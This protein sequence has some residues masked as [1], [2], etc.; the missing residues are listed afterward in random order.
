MA[1][2]TLDHTVDHENDQDIWS[3][4]KEPWRASYGKLMM[5]YFLVSDAFT[6]AGF[7]IAYGTL[8]SLIHI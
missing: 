3:G 6:F 1:T 7:L 8:L 4:G 5:W 2:D